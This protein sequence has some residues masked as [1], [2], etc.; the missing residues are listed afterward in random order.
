MKGLPAHAARP[1]RRVE[2]MP[3][4]RL[5]V[6]MLAFAALAQA[7][8]P[9]AKAAVC[10]GCHGPK[11]TSANP[12]WPNLAGQH[13]QYLVKQ[14]RDFRDGKRMDPVMAPMAKGLTDAEIGALAAYYAGMSGK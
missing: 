14:T 7:A 5:S 11:G 2:A 10:A 13:K 8:E 4:F 6:A 9:P 1:R 3:R 12:Q